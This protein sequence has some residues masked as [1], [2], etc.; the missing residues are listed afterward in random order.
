MS[1][2]PAAQHPATQHLEQLLQDRPGPLYIALSGGIDSLALMTVAARVRSQH[3]EAVH[4]VSEAV[5]PEATD[6]CRQLADRFGWR[7]TVLDAGE[8]NDP[9]Y[10]DNPVNRCYYC[11]SNLFERIAEQ[12]DITGATIATGT[13]KDDLGD[14]RP[15]LIAASENA[16]WQPYA[17]AE[18]DKPMIR[19]IARTEQLGE[20]AELPAQPCLSSRVETGIAINARD[21]LFVHR[22]ERRLAVELGEGDIRC[23][24]TAAGVVAQLP[25]QTAAFSDSA[26]HAKLDQLLTALCA[27]D[28]RHFA[29]IE[30]YRMG[31]AFLRSRDG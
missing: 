24:I 18:I 16:V 29:R 2:R 28:N 17:E 19:E 11:K 23:R 12:I 27:S 6:R 25:A 20:L 22:V 21:L 10:I 31:S 15:G 5:P 4:A 13:N 26:V 3:T 7:L 30:P 1:K 9:R 14:Y 8:F